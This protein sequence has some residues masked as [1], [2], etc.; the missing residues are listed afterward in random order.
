MWSKPNRFAV[1]SIIYAN[2]VNDNLEETTKEAWL[3]NWLSTLD[4]SVSE[5]ELSDNYEIVHA[6]LK[7]KTL[8]LK[9]L[10]AHLK[11]VNK[12]YPLVTA[13]LLAFCLE[14]NQVK[15]ENYP[16]LINKYLD[17]YNEIAPKESGKLV[18]A[19]LLKL[20][21]VNEVSEKNEDTSNT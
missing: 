12:T 9:K 2:L 20:S 4:N 11:D 15:S 6:Y 13:T 8:H 17:I 5:E 18:H 7:E 16:T 3:K 21:T 19:V 1:I 10:A 14:Q